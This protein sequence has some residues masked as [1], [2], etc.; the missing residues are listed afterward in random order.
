MGGQLPMGSGAGGEQGRPPPPDFEKN[1]DLFDY[2]NYESDSPPPPIL[3]S[4]G[5]HAE[6]P[7]CPYGSYSFDYSY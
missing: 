5:P 4:S 7:P 2:C 3:G 6:L 1:M